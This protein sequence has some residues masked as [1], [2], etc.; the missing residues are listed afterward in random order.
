MIELRTTN[1]RGVLCGESQPMCKWP[2]R[3]V[4]EARTLRAQGLT[5]HEI[6]ARL[7]GPHHTSVWRWVAGVTRR[8]AARVI[9]RRVRTSTK[10]V[11]SDSKSG[12]DPMATTTYSGVRNSACNNPL[13][14]G[15]ND[16][17]APT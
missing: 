2:D 17:K 16:Q 4:A 3:M 7:N 13:E 11:A 8:P 5:I 15:E 9:A 12:V 10:P 1:A 14:S 6:A